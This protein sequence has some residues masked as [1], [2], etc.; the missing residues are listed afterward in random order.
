[1]FY[2]YRNSNTGNITLIYWVIVNSR[3]MWKEACGASISAF[4]WRDW[5]KPQ[6]KLKWASCI[7]TEIRIAHLPNTSLELVSLI[8]LA[9]WKECLRRNLVLR[10]SRCSGWWQRPEETCR[11]NRMLGSLTCYILQWTAV[12]C[13]L[14]T[15][16]SAFAICTSHK[17]RSIYIGHTHKPHL[18]Y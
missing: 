2:L 14:M 16:V 9:R 10:S 17:Q 8:Q 3:N 6:I 5:G 13:L 18:S 7:L 4:A 12:L 15:K 1:M 11:T